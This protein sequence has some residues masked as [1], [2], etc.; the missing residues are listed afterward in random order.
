MI[1]PFLREWQCN[2][3]S[4][5]KA[6]S[7]HRYHGLPPPLQSWAFHAM[8]EPQVPSIDV[9]ADA[10]APLE[11]SHMPKVERDVIFEIG[12]AIEPLNVSL[13]EQQELLDRVDSRTQARC[14]CLSQELVRR[15]SLS[16]IQ[17]N[18]R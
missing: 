18:N 10:L 7:D 3:T 14:A 8:A 17:D 2:F 9:V 16:M 13:K 15:A 12:N 11:L 5:L 1:T 4:F 6:V